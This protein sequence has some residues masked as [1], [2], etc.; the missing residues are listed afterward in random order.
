[1]LLLLGVVS[2]VVRDT[3]NTRTHTCTHLCTGT[4]SACTCTGTCTC[5]HFLHAY[6]HTR[7]PTG[8]LHD[9]ESRGQ[10]PEYQRLL[11]ECQALYAQ[12]R[13]QLVS[14]LVGAR[15]AG[16]CP[17]MCVSLHVCMCTVNG[18]VFI[19]MVAT[20]PAAA[21]QNSGPVHPVL[22]L[23]RC[24]KCSCHGAPPPPPA[25]P[26]AGD[27]GRL[28]LPAFTRVGCELLP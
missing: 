6:T 27:Q 13:V 10:R 25:S 4:L 23:S 1:M 5:T 3:R 8:V 17:R 22:Q 20:T 11:A 9:I 21:L 15:I 2:L 12:A 19:N 16:V 28:S 7:T 18:A 14:P 26:A 24:R